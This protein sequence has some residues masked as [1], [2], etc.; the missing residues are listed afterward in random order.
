MEAWNIKET[1]TEG[2]Q[3]VKMKKQVFSVWSVWL[4]VYLTVQNLNGYNN[5]YK[6]RLWRFSDDVRRL[7]CAWENPSN[8]DLS[9]RSGQD[10]VFEP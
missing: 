6:W 1:I 10:I 3:A 7:G 4:N 8:I 2:E 5:K 9:D